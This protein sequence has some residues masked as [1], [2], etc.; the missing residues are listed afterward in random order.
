MPAL[1]RADTKR[2]F[3]KLMKA[4]GKSK[5][6][7]M[8]GAYDTSKVKISTKENRIN[9]FDQFVNEVKSSIQ[10]YVEEI[11]DLFRKNKN[12]KVNE[13]RILVQEHINRIV[14]YHKQ[15]MSALNAYKELTYIIGD[16]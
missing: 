9:S 15:G 16:I 13:A 14:E 4:S 8:Y 1:P 7:T 10:I 6:N 3:K 2:R 12:L 11:I 5:I